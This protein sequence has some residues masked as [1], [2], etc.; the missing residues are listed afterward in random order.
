MSYFVAGG[1]T[2]TLADNPNYAEYR[3]FQKGVYDEELQVWSWAN[4]Y[5][6]QYRDVTNS[7]TAPVHQAW[8]FGGNYTPVASM[9]TANANVNYLGS[10]TA[11]AQTSSWVDNKADPATTVTFNNNWRVSGTSALVANFGTGDFSGTLHSTNWIGKTK[12]GSASINVDT[13]V[14]SINRLDPVMVPDVKLVGKITTSTTAGA[15]PNQI[16]GTANIDN[17]TYGWITT[18][19]SNP[20]YGG[21]FGAG[22]S[23]VAGA[24][25]V[26]TAYPAPVGGNFAVN[27]DLRGYLS[28]SGMFHG[29]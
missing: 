28:M 7:G 22:A 3:Y 9:P 27:D 10:W 16:N 13:S 12:D 20:M 26:D 8:S 11:T 29:Q 18:A 5:A 25:A 15:H 17:T 2:S 14:A 4:S 23:E 19:G 21:F 1:T 6:T 24:F